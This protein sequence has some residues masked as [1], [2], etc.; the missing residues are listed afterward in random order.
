MRIQLTKMAFSLD[1]E[2]WPD[3]TP[4]D[5]ALNYILLLD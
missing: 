1:F 2:F 4:Y 3:G 5:T